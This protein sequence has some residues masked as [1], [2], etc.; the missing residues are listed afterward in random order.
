MSDRGNQTP[1]TGAGEMQVVAPHQTW[2]TR[3]VLSTYGFG[4]ALNEESLKNLKYCLDWLC[5]LNADLGK[6]VSALKNAV[7]ELDDHQRS[8][9]DERI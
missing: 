7:G 5:F 1:D 9:M 3:I 2:P 4:A 8:Q 6:L